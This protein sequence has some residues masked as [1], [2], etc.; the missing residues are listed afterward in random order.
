[1]K[2]D[3]KKIEIMQTP[4]SEYLLYIR[5]IVFLLFHGMK[6][7]TNYLVISEPLH[8]LTKNLVICMSFWQ[9][10]ALDIFIY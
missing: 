4:V 7:N 10:T 3:L 9:L 8:L 1:M 2:C 6:Y 5:C